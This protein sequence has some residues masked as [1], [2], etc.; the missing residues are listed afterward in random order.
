MDRKRYVCVYR[1]EE[2]AQLI[3][4]VAVPKTISQADIIRAVALWAWKC[5]YSDKPKNDEE[6][7]DVD[8]EHLSNFG[9]DE[10]RL[11]DILWFEVKSTFGKKQIGKR[12]DWYGET[13]ESREAYNAAW[14]EIC[15]ENKL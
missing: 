15:K 8:G 2:L 11:T 5:V 14:L 9:L 1:E 10:G 3:C 7:I 4:V 6:L 13:E 12:F